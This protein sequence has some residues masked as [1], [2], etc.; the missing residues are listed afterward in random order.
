V[1]KYAFLPDRGQWPAP[2][3]RLSLSVLAAMVVAV[4]VTLVPDTV[5]T[6]SVRFLLGL[7]C[8]PWLVIEFRR[9]RRHVA[10]P[11]RPQELAS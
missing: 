4:A 1:L 11:L 7:V 5:V 2:P 10:S 8:L 9:M 6:M 3:R